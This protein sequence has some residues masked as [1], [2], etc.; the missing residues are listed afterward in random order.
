MWPVIP[1]VYPRMPPEDLV[2]TSVPTPETVL[3]VART[4]QSQ[5]RIAVAARTRG[6]AARPYHEPGRITHE[7][8]LDL[9]SRADVG[10]SPSPCST[11]DRPRPSRSRAAR[12]R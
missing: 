6:G 9:R 2:D 5:I 11:G 4:T 1:A 12:S 3:L 8:E 7:L 10:R